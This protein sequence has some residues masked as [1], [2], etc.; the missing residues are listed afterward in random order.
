MIEWL[1][2]AKADAS[3]KDEGGLTPVDTAHKYGASSKSL[4]VSSD[5]GSEVT[6]LLSRYSFGTGGGLEYGKNPAR[7]RLVAEMRCTEIVV[8]LNFI[9]TLMLNLVAMLKFVVLLDFAI[10][11]ATAD[12]SMAANFGHYQ[13]RP[14]EKRV[15]FRLVPIRR[16]L[17]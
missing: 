11:P 12:F 16:N 4:D 6:K 9:V 10:L 1:L 5:D 13:A 3:A 2:S 14:A 8:I 17:K 15:A 7:T